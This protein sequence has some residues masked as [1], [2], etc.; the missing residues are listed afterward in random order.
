[1]TSYCSLLYLFIFLPA[2]TVVWGI[3][4]RSWRPFVLLGASYAFFWELSG[5][6][7]V[8]LFL[9]TLVIYLAGL[10][11]SALQRKRNS[12]LKETQKSEHREIKAAFRCRQRLVLALSAAAVL[13]ILIVLKYGAFINENINAL[14]GWLCLPFCLPVPCFLLPVG[15]S[16]YSL[17]AVSYL[18]DVYRETIEADRNPARLALYMSFFPQLMEGPI[19]R[20]AQTAQAL[21]QGQK[22]TFR[23]LAFGIQRIAFGMLKKAV[24]A[25]RLNLLIETVFDD[26]GQ[27]DGGV[28]AL[29]MFFYT[30]QLYMEFSGTM[31]VVAGSAELFGVKLPENFRRP[32]LA[33]TISKFWTRWHITLGTWFK[34]YVFYPLSMSKRLT[35]LTVRARKRLGNHYGPLPAAAAALLAVW[36]GNGLWHGAG[37]RYIFFGLY[38]FTWILFE[39]LTEPVVRTYAAKWHI[40]RDGVFWRVM[41]VSRTILLVNVGEL[42]FRADSLRDGFAMFGRMTGNFTLRSLGNGTILTLGMD[43]LDFLIAGITIVLVLTVHILCER[44]V[45]VRE[46]VARQTLPVRWALYG[47]LF[48][49]IVVFGAYGEGYVPV[50]PIY[51]GF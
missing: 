48:L 12:L 17:Q 33:P 31:D 18:A 15:I 1:M 45:A 5:K 35:R 4:P 39:N 38:H 24:I 26:Y 46:S 49:Y 16:F 41:Q 28:I 47:A 44:G 27:Y 20:Y 23:N 36:L 9:T 40:N 51:A 37:W 50:D 32:F 43:S 14:A 10:R 6:L 19:C 2:V 25:D 11:L 3:A 42:F 29:S 30:C 8:F 7:V 13:G 34:D 21:W 22:L